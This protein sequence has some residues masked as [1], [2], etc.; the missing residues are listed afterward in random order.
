MNYYDFV[1]RIDGLLKERGLK[2]QQLADAC[3]IT[4]GNIPKWK[5][6]QSKPIAENVYSAAQFLNVS[7]E[8]LL[9]GTDS[10]ELSDQERHL[11]MM[12]RESDDRGKAA[13]LDTAEREYRHCLGP[14][15]DSSAS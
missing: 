13:I 5:H 14:V 8:W 2:R 1:E 10:S 9:T 3:G 12:Y 11:V 7:M 6:G 15:A 4:V